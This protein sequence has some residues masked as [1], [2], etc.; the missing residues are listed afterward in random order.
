MG[1][2]EL[3][4]AARALAALGGAASPGAGG[5]PAVLLKGGHRPGATVRDLLVAGA[6]ER[7]FEHPRQETTSTHGTGCTLSSAIAARLA[8]GAALEEAVEGAIGYLQGAIA[9]AYPLGRGHGPVDHLYRLF[10][11]AAGR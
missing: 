3:A 1:K 4:G 9:A 10:P 2:A 8:L 6:A 11:R 5:R 7:F